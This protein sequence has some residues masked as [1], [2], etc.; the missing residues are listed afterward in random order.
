RLGALSLHAIQQRCGTSIAI[1]RFYPALRA[2][3]LEYGPFFRAIELLHRGNGEV[4]TRVR[5][6][7]HL[8]TAGLHPALLD[9]CLH[10]Y[11]A[12]VE[13]YGDFTQPPEELRRTYLP[14]GVERFSCSGSAS[15]PLWVHAVRRPHEEDD[16]EALTV[17]IAVYQDDGSLAASIE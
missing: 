11:P 5:L 14:V 12:L 9:A 17:D 7:E 13:A 8:S 10:V 1:D 15:G 16:R 2:L 4:L 6:H 3:G